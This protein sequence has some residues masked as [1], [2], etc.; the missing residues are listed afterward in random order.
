[1]LNPLAGP[2]YGIKRTIDLVVSVVAAVALAPVVAVAVVAIRL[3][4]RGPALLRQTRVGLGGRTFTALKLRTMEVGNDASLHEAHL[5]A[6]IAGDTATTIQAD[7]SYKLTDPRVTGVGRV[8]RRLSIDEVPQ[9]LNVIKG[10]MSIVG[11]R[12]A[13]PFEVALHDERQRRRTAVRPGMTGLWQVS[14]RAL[15]AYDAMIALDLEYVD[16]WSPM[17]DVRILLRTL[18]AWLRAE[19]R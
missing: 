7:G 10:D 2:G 12:P 16:R 4:S 13:L 1:M 19:T 5:A 11:P 18:P 17:L 3:T 9:L 14:G 15:V 6:L 8:L